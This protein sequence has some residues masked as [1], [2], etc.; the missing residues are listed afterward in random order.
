MKKNY[1]VIVPDVV[2]IPV[3]EFAN[4]LTGL[5]EPDEGPVNVSYRFREHSHV[6][7]F[8]GRTDAQDVK[9]ED[10]ERPEEPAKEALRLGVGGVGLGLQL[11]CAGFAHAGNVTLTGGVLQK[12]TK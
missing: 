10:D 1:L 4:W 7:E 5:G 3:Q 12:E 8:V 6:G 9:G 11:V 2:E